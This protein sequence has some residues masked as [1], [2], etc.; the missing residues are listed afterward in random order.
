MISSLH[1]FGG[2]GVELEYMI[3]DK[4]SLSIKPIADKIFYDLIGEFVSDVEFNETAWSNELV[5]HV[6]EIKTNGPRKDLNKLDELFSENVKAINKILQNY[7][8]MLL[9]T[10]MHPF[11]NPDERN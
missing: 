8:S 7:D 2:Y 5:L 4:N 9:P 10:G 1:L 6:I 11:M 3:V